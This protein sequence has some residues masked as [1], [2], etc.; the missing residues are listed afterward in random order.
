M[1]KT[2]CFELYRCSIF[3]FW[4]AFTDFLFFK[5]F[6]IT[7]KKW[8]FVLLY[9]LGD[10]L[11]ETNNLFSNPFWFCFDMNWENSKNDQNEYT[12]DSWEYII[13]FKNWRYRVFYVINNIECLYSH[14]DKTCKEAIEDALQ[15][16]RLSSGKSIPPFILWKKYGKGQ[17]A[18]INFRDISDA[19]EYIINKY[20]IITLL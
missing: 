20:D 18:E 2:F 9:A 10:N 8:L 5:F 3:W 12:T 16:V 15:K 7:T 19:T 13:L 6:Y 14:V 11:Q 1:A 4:Y 17:F